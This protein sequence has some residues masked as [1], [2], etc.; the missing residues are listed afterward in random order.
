MNLSPKEQARELVNMFY[1]SLPNNGGF[2]GLNNI[3][4]RWEEGKKCALI[5][6]NRIQKLPNIQYDSIQYKNDDESQYDYWEEVKQEIEK[7]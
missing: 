6:V 3:N 2:T 7:L 1:I 5:A 4:S